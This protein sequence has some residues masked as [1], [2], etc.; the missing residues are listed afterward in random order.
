MVLSKSVIITYLLLVLATREFF[1]LEENVEIKSFSM[2]FKSIKCVGNKP[3]YVKIKFCFVKPVSRSIS[4]VN[5]GYELLED[6]MAPSEV[7]N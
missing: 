6:Y 7:R 3:E 5:V 4:T 1:T 2:K